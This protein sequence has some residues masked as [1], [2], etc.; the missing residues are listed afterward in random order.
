[1]DNNFHLQTRTQLK[2]AYTI[3]ILPSI[4]RSAYRF[5]IYC[6][7]KTHSVTAWETYANRSWQPAQSAAARRIGNIYLTV[8]IRYNGNRT[9]PCIKCRCNIAFS[10]PSLPHIDHRPLVI[11]CKK[12]CEV[13]VGKQKKTVQRLTPHKAVIWKQKSDEIKRA[14]TKAKKQGQ[15]GE[16]RCS[17][18]CPSVKNALFS[19]M[20]TKEVKR[21]A[22][23]KILH[24]NGRSGTNL[25]TSWYD[26]RGTKWLGSFVPPILGW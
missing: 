24:S 13:V 2:F 23:T 14:L 10:L 5:F 4:Y 15:H 12:F 7:I 3:Y 6:Q 21:Y 16:Q 17:P 20:V 18:C 26:R 8:H 22:K 19:T 9:V 25:L 1:M 11:V